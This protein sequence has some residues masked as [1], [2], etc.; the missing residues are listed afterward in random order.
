VVACQKAFHDNDFR[1]LE[2][3]VDNVW[4]TS[5]F[6]RKHSSENRAFASNHACRSMRSGHGRPAIGVE[7]RLVWKHDAPNGVWGPLRAACG[8]A[9]PAAVAARSPAHA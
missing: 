8:S 7:T 9:L 2:R 4:T 6:A 5:E 1:G 3:I